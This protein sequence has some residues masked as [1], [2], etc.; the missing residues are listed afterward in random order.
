MRTVLVAAPHPDDETLGCGGTLLRHKS[1]GSD[2][3]W[4]IFTTLEGSPLASHE[5]IKRR[6]KEI[7]KVSNE[8]GFQEVHSLGYPTTQ[9][10]RIAK[11]KIIS[12]VSKVVSATEPDI[13]YAPFGLDAHS[14]HRVV[15]ESIMA[16]SK[17]FRFPTVK[18]IR[19]YE[20]L[21]E[22]EFGYQPENQGFKPNTFVDITDFFEKKIEI[23]KS[24]K[25]EI[26]DFPHPRSEESIKALAQLRGS[27]ANVQ[28]AE[29]FMTLKDII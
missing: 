18:T 28:F 6:E 23:I 4:L 10:D 22:T 29:A 24:F 9:L 8:Y 19:I 21:S 3:H 16:C 12:A 5:K 13:I 17:S 25:D 11:Q 26:G 7:S 20:T 2:L 1:E 14:D 27:Y 15:F